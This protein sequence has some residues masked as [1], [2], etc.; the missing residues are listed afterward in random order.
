MIMPFFNNLQTFIYDIIA[1][2]EPWKN[3]K[4]YNIYYLH[5]DIF[6]LIYMDHRSTRVCFY[7]NKKVD[8]SS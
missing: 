6:Y 5:K 8:V 7:I 2:Q 1:T 4:F 3:S